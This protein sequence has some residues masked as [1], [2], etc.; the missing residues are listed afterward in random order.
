M[1]AIHGPCVAA[2]TAVACLLAGSVRAQVPDYSDVPDRFRVE[3]GGFRIGSDTELTF[4]AG[5]GGIVPPVDFEGLN[6]PDTA[7]RFYLEGFWRPWRRHQFSLSWYRHNRDGD[8]ITLS[9]DINWGGETVTAGASVRAT[10]HSSYLSGV[11]RFAAYKNDRFEIGPSV[12]I[13]Y[14]SIDAGIE[15]EIGGIGEGPSR[16][17]DRS[18]S[19]DQPTGDLG[20]YLY[21]WPLRRLLVRGELRY[22]VVKPENAEA[23]VTD[24]RAAVLYHPWRNV[25]V[26]LQYTYNKFR[27]DREILSTE[28]GGRLRYSGGQVVVSAAF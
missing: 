11:Y 19:L 9:R 2:L 13:G 15:G 18:R 21:W 23:S 25:G 4:S 20:G 12:G 17:F 10:T 27:Y 3:A 1:R 16:Q 22:I 24:G 28:L 6:L 5:G 14:L 26:G 7:T 8:T